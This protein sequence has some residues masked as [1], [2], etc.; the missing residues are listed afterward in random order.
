MPNEPALLD[1]NVLVYSL[2][3]DAPQ[4]AACRVL[5]EKARSAD[6]ALF[7][8]AQTMAEFY[9]VVTNPRR[10][11]NPRSAA[12]AVDTIERFLAMPGLALV[13]QPTD[14][15]ARWCDLLRDHAVVGSDIFDLQ[16]VA[17]MMASGIGRIYTF[18]SDDFKPFSRI[19]VLTP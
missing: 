17:T 16:L 15:V 5:V 18:N 2:Y 13:H 6:A 12:E 14:V 11:T 19:Q 8:A 3:H 7:V 1:T 10:A 4:H 9:S